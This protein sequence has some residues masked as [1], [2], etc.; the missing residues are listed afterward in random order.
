MNITDPD[1]LPWNGF[2]FSLPEGKSPGWTENL[3]EDLCIIDMDNRL[4]DEPGYIWSNESMAWDKNNPQGQSLG[5]L[6]H[7]MYSKIHGYKYYF[8]HT[9]EPFDRRSSWMKPPVVSEILKNHKVCIY[10]DSDAIFHH[11]E[12]PMEWLMNYWSVI[13]GE[14]TVTLAE[15]PAAFRNTEKYGEYWKNTGFLIMQNTTETH[16]LMKDWW[17]CP[18]DKKY[19]DCHK[20]AFANPGKPTDQAGFDL[21]IYPDPEYKPHINVLKCEEANGYHGYK[22]DWQKCEGTFIAHPWTGKNSLLNQYVGEQ[23][24]GRWLESL[25]TQFLAEKDSFFI[26]QSDLL[27]E[28]KFRGD[29]KKAPKPEDN[30]PRKSGKA[31][32][33]TR[34]D[35]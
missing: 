6:Q 17:E 3:G 31:I 30:P 34:I 29:P 13:P 26:Q 4:W 20:H 12:V 7:W 14:T 35:A 18:T 28:G 9:E 11:P 22:S 25:H 27:G 24:P 33:G 10:A 19:P 16:K 2:K 23:M 8:V 32:G 1:Y 15:D 21:F 5:I